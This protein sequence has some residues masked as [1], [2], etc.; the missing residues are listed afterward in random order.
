MTARE[1]YALTLGAID[2]IVRNTPVPYRFAYLDTGAPDWLRE[3]LRDRPELD[4]IRFDEP[5]WPQQAR[6]RYADSIETDYVVFIDNDV[7]VEPGWLDA[8]A[9][10][11]DDTGAGVVGPLYLWG[12]G[13]TPDKIHMAGGKLSEMH[14]EGGRVLDEFHQ[15]INE[16]PE[17]V[18]NELYR[19]PCD[20]VEYHCML[21]RTDL[22]QGGKLLDPDIYCVH[23]HIDTAL[24]A[25]RLGFDV[26]LEPSARVTYLAF[27]EYMLD[28]LALF[29]I[30]GRRPM[31]KP[32]LRPSPENGMS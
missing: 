1:R 9:A 32:A 12:D 8:L 7:Q 17:A 4:V 20:F 21:I 5:L 25:R 16:S 19:R 10:C 18:A 31:L 6:A 24:A 11:A 29:R 13:T 3:Q 23:E 27:R 15:L 2:N 26:F 22:V 28:D 30:A 14:E